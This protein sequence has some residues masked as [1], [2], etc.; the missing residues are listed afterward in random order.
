MNL[1]IW[2][3]VCG[4]LAWLWAAHKNSSKNKDNKAILKNKTK[5]TSPN[6][7]LHQQP[8]SLC[9]SLNLSQCLEKELVLRHSRRLEDWE[10][11]RWENFPEVRWGLGKG[12]LPRSCWMTPWKRKDMVPILSDLLEQG[13][14]LRRS[15][16]T[17]NLVCFIQA[18]DSLN[19]YYIGY[20]CFLWWLC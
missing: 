1:F 14:T 2:H 5:S 4:G 19:H 20:G 13:E 6:T 3:D 12:K 15:G 8:Q 9:S 7:L 17:N 16:P 18:C 10:N 11:Q